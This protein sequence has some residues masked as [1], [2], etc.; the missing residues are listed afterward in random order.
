MSSGD[1][2]ATPVASRKVRLA[3]QR[4]RAKRVKCDGGIPAC[5]NCS[6]A[7]VSCVDVD[8]RNAGVSIPRDHT[9]KCQARIKWLEEN[10]RLL[11]PEF[12][13]SKGPNINPHILNG[14]ETPTGANEVGETAHLQNTYSADSNDRT[15]E[16]SHKKRSYASLLTSDQDPPS[17]EARSVAIDLGMISLHSD[18]RQQSY[19]GSSSG[20][21]FTKLI[22]VDNEALSRPQ[23]STPSNTAP[24][25]RMAEPRH[26]TET[27]SLIYRQ[28]SKELP[29]PQEASTLFGIYFREIHIDHPFLHPQSLINA[30]NALVFCVELGYSGNMD[31]N[32]WIEGITPFPYNG[33]LEITGDQNFIPITIFTATFHVFMVFSLA[34]TLLTRNKIFDFSPTR[35]HQ[36]AIN[37]ATE[38]ISSISLSSLQ[39]ILLLIVQG[40]IGPADF[41]IW[42]LSHI[43]MSYCIDLGLHREPTAFTDISPTT[44]ILRKLIF[45]TVYN[46][47]R[48]IATIQGRPLGIR[49]ETFDIQLPDIREVSNE[50]LSATNDPSS[51][52][53]YLRG[54]EDLEISIHRFKLDRHISEI[55]LLFY[56][57]PN[58]NQVF[59]FSR[60]HAADQIRI[61]ASLDDWFAKIKNTCSSFNIHNATGRE[62]SKLHCKRLKLEVLY[63]GAVALLYQ[64]S[65]ALPQPTQTALHF[66]YESACKRLHIYNHLNDIQN[67]YFNWRNI[68]GIF[69]SGATIIFCFWS[70]PEI[71]LIIP[72]SDALRDLRTCSNLLSIGGQWWPSVRGGKDSF[73]R[74]VDLTV[75]RLS[76]LQNSNSSSSQAQ[77]QSQPRY[78]HAHFLRRSNITS[79]TAKTPLVFPD[80]VTHDNTLF[81]EPAGESEITAIDTLMENFFADY[82][83]GDWS[84]DPFSAPETN[85]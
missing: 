25:H 85:I 32:G 5:G 69:A 7:G 31:Q 4:C 24:Q 55:K 18:S 1:G 72:F 57:L 22:G 21:L 50:I 17:V 33:R 78:P 15:S 3:C 39:S 44:L 84:W 28:I 70:S 66:C 71:Q 29:D 47:D 11:D 42:T 80:E 73:D 81:T 12:D 59:T 56:H 63:Y 62:S 64:P 61:K 58:N 40:M 74:I 60:D 76:Y 46:L 10:I 30:Y 48:T 23:S 54:T 45:Y 82:L 20:L 37:T 2:V 52:C 53:H 35:F 36:V 65:H 83:Q 43:A 6:R 13:L 14:A 16:T 51:M 75:K 38:G 26:S 34:A 68:H 77:L 27:Y 8:G 19:L 67:L 49:D 79:H 9:A 41:N